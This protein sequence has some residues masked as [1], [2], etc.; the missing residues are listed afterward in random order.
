MKSKIEFLQNVELFSLLSSEEISRIIKSLHS[1]E[2][3]ADEILFKEGDEGNELFIVMT[4]KVASYVVLPKGTKRE[5]AEFKPG[6][7]FGEMSIFENTPRSATC[8]TKEHCSLLSLRER[9]LFELILYDPEIAIK[10]MYR[11]LNITTERLLD[12]S[13]FLSDMVQWGEE[14]RKRAITDELTGIYNR[15]FLDDALV[16]YFEKAKNNGKPLSLIMMD[17]DNF[18]EHSEFFNQKQTNRV[19]LEVVSVFKKYFRENDI[20]AR[21]G[22]DEFTVIMPDTDLKSAF[23]F[24]EKIRIAV[25]E[26]QLSDIMKNNIRQITISQGI[27]SYPE[28]ADDL[29]SLRVNADK[30]LYKAKLEGRNKV[31]LAE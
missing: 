30:A 11:M 31:I 25:S 21:Y 15:R 4:G 17:I 6:D 13:E 27:S 24:A 23:T 22:G 20:I 16:D 8:Y 12:R 9:D 10:I 5:I 14:A 29:E 28:N 7:F 1:V 2:K 3:E 19:I 18:R 26:L